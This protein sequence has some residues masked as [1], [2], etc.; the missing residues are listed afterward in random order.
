MGE[1]DIDRIGLLVQLANLKPHP[2]S[3]PINMLMKVKGLP[4]EDNDDVDPFDFIR[5]IALARILMPH[6]YVRLSAGRE[7][8]HDEAQALAFMAGA[9][10]IFYG[11][12]L[13]TTANPGANRDRQ[14][15]DRLGM[16]PEEA[17]VHAQP[18]P[19][20][21]PAFYDAVAAN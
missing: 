5:T 13:L 15:L 21:S 7:Y 19:E 20:N 1:S 10:S 6:S 3:V 18:Q 16:Q 14:L 17:V 4:M 9:N 12:K 11:D 2:E 8:M